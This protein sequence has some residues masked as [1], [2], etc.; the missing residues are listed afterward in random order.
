MN[1]LSEGHRNAM[2][3]LIRILPVVSMLA[4]AGCYSSGPGPSAT[5]PVVTQPLST[6]PAQLPP[7]EQTQMAMALTDVTGFVDPTALGLLSA[8]GRTEATA[9]QFNALEYGRPGAPRDWQGGDGVSSGRVTVGPDLN[10]NNLRCRNFTH[11]VT[12][13]G[14]AYSRTGQACR[15]PAAGWMVTNSSVG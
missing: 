5:G 1:T 12:V 7:R 3:S 2:T 4:L 9:A 6:Q 13:S 10:V 11:T 15:E 8:A 14:K